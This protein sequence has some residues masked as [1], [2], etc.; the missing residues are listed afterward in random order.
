[1]LFLLRPWIDH[2]SELPSTCSPQSA[3]RVSRRRLDFDD[4]GPEICQQS[5]T[6]WR[7]YIVTNLQ[8]TKT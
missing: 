6:E 8:H 4:L 1:M 5:R 2:H 7:R 3:D